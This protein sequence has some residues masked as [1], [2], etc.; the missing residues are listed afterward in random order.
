MSLPPPPAGGVRLLVVSVA[1][2]CA[3]A[4]AHLA[5]DTRRRVVVPVE[6]E[7]ALGVAVG[8]QLGPS[9]QAVR[10]TRRP[11]WLDVLP[12]LTARLPQAWRTLPLAE[13]Y[14]AGVARALLAEAEI[15]VLEKPGGHLEG[16]RVRALVRELCARGT[17]VICIERRLRLVAALGDEAWLIDRRQRLGPVACAGLL[18]DE[19][20][21]ALAFGGTLPPAALASA[22][23]EAAATAEAPTALAR[24]DERRPET[25]F[26]DEKTS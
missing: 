18:D 9:V 4:L 7:G 10:G 23:P 15:L 2:T 12:E 6:P 26:S 25:P 16:G 22:A 11:A 14:L 1:T 8:Q 24:N 20:A 13:R 21:W 17:A 5:P 19:R 3:E